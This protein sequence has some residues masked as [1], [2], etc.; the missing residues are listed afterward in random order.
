ML[1]ALLTLY[2]NRYCDLGEDN[3]PLLYNHQ[4]HVKY[5][6]A[7]D[8]GELF[9]C[10][11]FNREGIRLFDLL[12]SRT[13]VNSALSSNYDPDYDI[14]GEITTPYE[15]YL[16]PAGRNFMFAPRKVGERF[17]LQHVSLPNDKEEAIY[18]ETL[19]ISPKVF[20]VH[21]FFSE[22]ESEILVQQAL[23]QTADTHKLQRSSTGPDGQNHNPT[24]TSEN[25]FDTHSPTAM[26][27]KRRCFETLGFPN[28][29]EDMADGL[30]ILR[31]N[32]SKAYV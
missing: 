18:L 26:I 23:D 4:E 31:Y 22:D 27:V 1:L 19:S 16:V 15:T 21:N 2:V 11:F 14:E 29:Q 20:E 17:N 5:Q 8:S 30:Q 6:A 3:T 25:A 13:D 12:G 10:S 28:Y 32:Q 24:R 9:P 7:A